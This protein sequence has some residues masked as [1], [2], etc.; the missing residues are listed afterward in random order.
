MS[1]G[2]GLGLWDAL[3]WWEGSKPLCLTP[4]HSLATKGAAWHGKQGRLRLEG[5]SFA[6]VPGRLSKCSVLAPASAQR[7]KCNNMG[8][9][10]GD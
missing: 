5:Q 6:L 9:S 1:P 8:V 2:V 10:R 4:A 7:G 3:C